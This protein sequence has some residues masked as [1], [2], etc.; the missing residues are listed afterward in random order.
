MKK[1]SKHTKLALSLETVRILTTQDLSLVVGG[2]CKATSNQSFAGGGGQG[3]NPG[4][5]PGGAP[6]PFT[7][8]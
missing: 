3:P 5:S 6:R 8:C 2:A 4:N 1:T 7:T